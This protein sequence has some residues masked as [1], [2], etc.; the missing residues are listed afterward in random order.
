MFWKSL[1]PIIYVG[2]VQLYTT[3]FNITEDQVNTMVTIFYDIN[4]NFYQN[5]VPCHTT[6]VVQ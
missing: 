4:G 1:G 3:Y 2:N 5:N 6:R